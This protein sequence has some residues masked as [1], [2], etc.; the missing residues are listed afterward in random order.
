MNSEQ[1]D[2]EIKKVLKSFIAE[3]NK[4]ELQAA[5][6]YDEICKENSKLD[7]EKVK[8]TNERLVDEIFAKYCTPKERKFGR[9]GTFQMPPAYDPKEEIIEI[10]YP[11]AKKAT[12][13]TQ[14]HTGMRN[15]NRYTLFYKNDGWLIDYKEYFSGYED[16]WVKA[17]L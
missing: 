13:E 16:K 7:P 5:E 10:T 17:I 9:L 14:Q 6:T 4:W 1:T 15:K 3:M 8:E 12:V 11:N 2:K